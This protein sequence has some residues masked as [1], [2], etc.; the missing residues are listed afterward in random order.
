MLYEIK[1]Y[2]YAYV[3]IECCD[4]LFMM[5]DYL[6]WL[7]YPNDDMYVCIHEI[8]WECMNMNEMVKLLE[9]F[10]MTI[11]GE[12]YDCNNYWLGMRL[13]SRIMIASLC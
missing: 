11:I 2:C 5:I 13:T 7:K 9:C 1:C 8:N 4:D 12:S 6:V 3:V 10:N